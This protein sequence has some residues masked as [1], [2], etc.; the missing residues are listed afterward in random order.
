MCIIK[1]RESKHGKINYTLTFEKK[2]VLLWFNQNKINDEIIGKKEIDISRKF[3]G[4]F[5]FLF[6]SI[7]QKFDTPNVS[8]Y[9]S[10]EKRFL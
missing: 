7:L 10:G 2:Y 1:K 4:F 6:F 8:F 9:L 3:K 5:C